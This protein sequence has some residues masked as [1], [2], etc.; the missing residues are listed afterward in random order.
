MSDL[1][2]SGEITTGCFIWACTDV[3]RPATPM[4]APAGL[5]EMPWR[6]RGQ[7]DSD[8]RAAIIRQLLGG[9]NRWETSVHRG[10]GR[11]R[12]AFF[13]AHSRSLIARTLT[14]RVYLM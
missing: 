8:R 10:G 7:P 3:A 4:L 5:E 6:E 9:C 2:R 1:D 11:A 13:F 14:H 12:Q